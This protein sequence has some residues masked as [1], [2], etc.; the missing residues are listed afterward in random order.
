MQNS[1]TRIPWTHIRWDIFTEPTPQMTIKSINCIKINKLWRA[2]FRTLVVQQQKMSS[3]VHWLRR[4][5]P[6]SI[7]SLKR[8]GLGSFST[9]SE[10]NQEGI[11]G[12]VLPVKVSGAVLGKQNAIECSYISISRV[13]MDIH[14]YSGK[15][16]RLRGVKLSVIAM[17][18]QCISVLVWTRL[19]GKDRECYYRQI[20]AFFS[21]GINFSPCVPSLRFLGRKET[22]LVMQMSLCCA[23]SYKL[24]SYKLNIAEL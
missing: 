5:L 2:G 7:A 18:V 12:L 4:L 13:D 6:T 21:S 10:I 22:E 14:V 15:K 24:K 16:K 20:L 11:W 8:V 17:D 9:T 1:E 23:S 3:L 19:Y